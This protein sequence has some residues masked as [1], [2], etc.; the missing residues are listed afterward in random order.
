MSRFLGPQSNQGAY[1]ESG[2][3]VEKIPICMKCG[4]FMETYVKS[5]GKYRLCTT[6]ALAS[7]SIKEEAQSVCRFLDEEVEEGE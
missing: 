3:P 6:Y 4:A 7:I 2:F 5:Y 1:V